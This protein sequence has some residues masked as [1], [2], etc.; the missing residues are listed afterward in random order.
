[1]C[2]LELTLPIGLDPVEQRLVNHSQRS[3]SRCDALATLDQ[4][5][6]LLLELNHS[7][8]DTFFGARSDCLSNRWFSSSCVVLC[9]TPNSRFDYAAAKTGV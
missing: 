5:H 8:R 2:T 4:P 7:A 1:M 6:C 9:V 3:G